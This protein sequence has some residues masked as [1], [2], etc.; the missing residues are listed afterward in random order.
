MSMNDR[1]QLQE[2]TSKAEFRS[3]HQDK[4]ASYSS[5]P[6]QGKPAWVNG[7]RAP[8]TV[9]LEAQGVFSTTPAVS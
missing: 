5:F 6:M 7:I 1:L 4:D 3:W 2:A 8:N 9:H